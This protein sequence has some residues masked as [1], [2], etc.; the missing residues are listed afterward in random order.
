MYEMILTI[1]VSC[2]GIVTWHNRVVFNRVT[3]PAY[4]P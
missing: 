2:L 3:A 4:P 1:Q